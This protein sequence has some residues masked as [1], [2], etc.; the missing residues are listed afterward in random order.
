MEEIKKEPKY[1]TSS[2][3]DITTLQELEE[4][5]AHFRSSNSAIIR[6]AIKSMYEKYKER[7]L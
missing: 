2:T 7:Q 6:I 3:L 5:A 1:I 4:M